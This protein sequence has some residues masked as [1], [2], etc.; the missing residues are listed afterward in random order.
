MQYGQDPG[1]GRL[2]QTGW[3]PSDRV[4][5]VEYAGT[6]A[7]PYINVTYISGLVAYTFVTVGSIVVDDAGVPAIVVSIASGSTGDSGSVVV[8]PIVDN[9]LPSFLTGNIWNTTSGWNASVSSQ[10]TLTTTATDGTFVSDTAARLT[11]DWFWGQTTNASAIPVGRSPRSPPFPPVLP[12][13]PRCPSPPPWAP[14]P[15]PASRTTR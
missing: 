11:L 12:R 15:A 1:Q 5:I 10:T 3:G 6:V 9:N 14:P 2:R 4:S 8:Q 13:P 7:R